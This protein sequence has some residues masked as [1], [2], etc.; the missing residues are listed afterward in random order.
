[1]DT[2][3]NILNANFMEIKNLFDLYV[4]KSNIVKIPDLNKR[5]LVLMYLVI[6]GTGKEMSIEEIKYIYDL[7]KGSKQEIYPSKSKIIKI[8]KNEFFNDVVVDE[9]KMLP[10]VQN[11][12]DNSFTSLLSKNENAIDFLESHLY[13]IDW[14]FLSDNKNALGLLEM[15]QDN[16]NW[17]NLSKKE[18]ATKLLENNIDKI[19]Y[20]S[21]SLNKSPFAIKLLEKN[22]DKINWKNLS[23]NPSAIKILKRNKDKIIWEKLSLNENPEILDLF[24]EFPKKVYWSYLAEN[25]NSKILNFLIDE[26]FNKIDYSK[27]STNSNPIAIN[28]LEKNPKQI[29]WFSFMFNEN[30]RVIKIIRNNLDLIAE[31]FEVVPELWDQLSLNPFAIDLLIKFPDKINWEMLSGNPEAINFLELHQD[32]LDQYELLSN[33]SIF[34]YNGGKIRKHFHK[35]VFSDLA[36]EVFKPSNLMNVLKY[37][38]NSDFG[39]D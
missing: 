10:W 6:F 12:F 13:L 29:N 5:L 28:L 23:K 26:N 31:D 7:Y 37:E 34:V 1:M 24:R 30:P 21:L 15:N 32:N 4:K 33:P 16:I 36:A 9:Y 35:N 8:F 2:V 19:D 39:S 18:Y 27:L 22:L 11:L 17:E 20:S 14:R 3:N 38:E 25:K